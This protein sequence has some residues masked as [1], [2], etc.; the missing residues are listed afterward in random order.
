MPDNGLIEVVFVDAADGRP[1][2]RTELP[3]EQLPE[4]FEPDTRLDLAGESWEVLHAA[5]A[6]RTAALAA[7]RTVLTLRRLRTVDPQEVAFSLPTICAELPPLAPPD[8]TAD[9]LVLHEDDWRQA[10]LVERRC[11]AEVEGQLHEVMRVYREH[12]RALGE[13]ESAVRV[14]DTLHL[15]ESPAR[16]LA[17]ALTRQRLFELLPASRTYAGVALP[18]G[19]GRVADSFAAQVGPVT[20]YGRCAGDRVVELGLTPAAAAEAAAVPGLAALMQEFDLL[21]VD[22]CAVRCESDG[23]TQ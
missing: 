2:G 7:G 6:D 20:V 17:G 3:A 12:S 10:E 15:R 23:V 1:F 22:W 13:G 4:S 5:P 8:G 9:D 21:L 18:D 19:Q 11:L 14:F 16:P